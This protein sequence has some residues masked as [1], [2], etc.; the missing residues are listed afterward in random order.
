MDADCF[1]TTSWSRMG[2]ALPLI[3][4]SVEVPWG[5]C[6][7]WARVT[8]PP[9]T[10]IRTW[11]GPHWVLATA[12][13]Y[14]AAEAG[15]LALEVGLGLDVELRPGVALGRDPEAP[16]VFDGRGDAAGPEGEG[17]CTTGVAEAVAVLV[18]VL[19]W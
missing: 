2:S 18:L 11:T 10:V 16:L 17:C 8:L 15:R 14:V 6:T 1:W 9:S 13:V 7:A 19:V 3:W 12:P 5:Y 4:A